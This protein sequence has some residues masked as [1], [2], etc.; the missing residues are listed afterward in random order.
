MPLVPYE[1]TLNYS[2]N[3]SA[4]QNTVANSNVATVLSPTNPDFAIPAGFLAIGSTFRINA[5]CYF[6]TTGTPTLNV[7]VYL[8]GVATALGTTGA[9]TT[10]NNAANQAFNLEYWIQCRSL[11]T[12]GSLFSGG[13]ACGIA[14]QTTSYTMPSGAANGTTAIN[15]TVA[16]TLT[17]GAT[18]SV[19]AVGNTIT[20]FIWTIEQAL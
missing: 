4:S 9:I 15:T 8:N 6:S 13:V 12:S 20:C 14:G 11:G 17:L 2:T 10:T 3:W 18:W 7:G 19:A 16:N 5:V 1:Q